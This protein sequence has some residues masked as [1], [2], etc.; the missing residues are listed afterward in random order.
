MELNSPSRLSALARLV[1]AASAT[2]V[3]VGLGAAL[4][5]GFDASSPSRW[6]PASPEVLAD[7]SRCDEQPGR[8][9][10]DRCRQQVALHGLQPANATV[11]LAAGDA[12]RTGAFRGRP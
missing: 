1:A 11:Q 7:L 12:S 6:L 8:A 3:T 2:G 5:G 9:D 4:L 10:R